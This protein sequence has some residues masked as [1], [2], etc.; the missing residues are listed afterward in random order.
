MPYLISYHITPWQK[1]SH[2]STVSHHIAV[3][4]MTQYTMPERGIIQY[5]IAWHNTP[6]QHSIN[7]P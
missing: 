6:Y 4:N 2:R 5:S 7:N 1:R 3:H